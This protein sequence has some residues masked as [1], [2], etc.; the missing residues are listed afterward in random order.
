[1]G[2]NTSKS[3][4]L[5]SRTKASRI[6][7]DALELCFGGSRGLAEPAL[8]LSSFRQSAASWCWACVRGRFQMIDLRKTMPS[9]CNTMYIGRSPVLPVRCHQPIGAGCESQNEHVR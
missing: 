7:G 9:D 1:M 6:G 5:A 8:S 3:T 4:R 2:R